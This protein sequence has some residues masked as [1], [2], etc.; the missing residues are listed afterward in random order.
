MKPT[1]LEL[2]LAMRREHDAQCPPNNPMGGCRCVPC[3]IARAYIA[4]QQPKEP[5]SVEKPIKLSVGGSYKTRDGHNAVVMRITDDEYYA[6]GAVVLKSGLHESVWRAET[7]GRVY[8]KAP[9]HNR[10]DIVIRE[11]V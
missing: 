5:T 4:T 9:K 1:V 8:S 7:G 3:V 11:T 6:Y 10:H 2:A